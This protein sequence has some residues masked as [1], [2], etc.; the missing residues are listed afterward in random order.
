MSYLSY[1]THTNFHLHIVLFVVYNLII[2]TIYMYYKNKEIKSMLHNLTRN[3]YYIHMY[4]M[5]Y[6]I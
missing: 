5:C 1:Y 4:F 6:E 2:Y 3:M